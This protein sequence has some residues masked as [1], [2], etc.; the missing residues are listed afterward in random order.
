ME[1]GELLSNLRP[2]KVTT[3]ELALLSLFAA[4]WIATQTIFGPILGQITFGPISF[5]GTVNRLMGWLLMLLL[6][7]I[8]GK[9]GRVTLMA[10][11]VAMVTR[12]L[13]R[14]ASLYTVAVGIGYAFGGFV[15][16]LLFF[17]PFLGSI[18]GKKRTLYIVFIAA[19]SG[20]VAYCPYLIYKLA[21]LGTVTFLITF[22]FYF[23]SMVMKIVFSI[24]GVLTG[25]SMQSRT[26]H[27]LHSFSMQN[28]Y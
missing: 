7:E 24:I 20:A 27:H 23:Q 13:R 1:R 9:F 17:L 28:S 22:P 5:H 10:S 4:L 2:E 6:A 11:V 21:T 12:L 8:T 14:S 16:D 26:V 15:F 3:R 25:L 19:I 18:D